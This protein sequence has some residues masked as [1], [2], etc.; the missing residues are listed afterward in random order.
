MLLVARTN[1]AFKDFPVELYGKT[2]TAEESKT[3]P[4]HAL[5]IGYSHYETQE[6]IAFAIRVAYGYSS[7]NAAQIARDMLEYYYNLVDEA[8]LL[9]G[10]A[11]TEGLTSTVTD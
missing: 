11:A 9:N 3:R 10:T 5:F 7:S 2:G 1:T 4:D 6:D 8:V